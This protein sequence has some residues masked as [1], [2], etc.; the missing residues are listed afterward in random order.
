MKPLLHLYKRK[1]E[2]AGYIQLNIIFREPRVPNHWAI[3]RPIW[4]SGFFL[5]KKVY[6]DSPF[7]TSKSV[8]AINF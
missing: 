5:F 6:T 2:F 7:H 8:Q 4:K 1:I 3:M